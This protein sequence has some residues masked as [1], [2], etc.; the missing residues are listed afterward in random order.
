MELNAKSNVK[1]NTKLNAKS[2]AKSNMKSNA[3]T[4]ATAKKSVTKSRKRTRTGRH[5]VQE[6]LTSNSGDSLEDELMERETRRLFASGGD[7]PPLWTEEPD[8]AGMTR[9]TREYALKAKKMKQ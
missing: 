1:L 2:N 5:R 3:K 7:A 6:E 9:A 4:T 8:L